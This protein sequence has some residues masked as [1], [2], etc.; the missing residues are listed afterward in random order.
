MKL[1]KGDVVEI[2]LT[3]N[4]S[5]IIKLNN[6]IQHSDDDNE[7]IFKRCGIV[8]QEAVKMLEKQKKITFKI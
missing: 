1:H 6:Y 3:E 4:G 8:W 7:Y 5:F 2:E